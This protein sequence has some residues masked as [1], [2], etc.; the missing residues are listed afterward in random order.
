M[1][2][3]GQLLN[4]NTI[5]QL[6]KTQECALK[7]ETQNCVTNMCTQE[8]EK[9]SKHEYGLLLRKLEEI[10]TAY[11]KSICRIYGVMNVKRALDY[12]LATPNVRNKGGYF[13]YML[14]QFKKDTPQPTAKPQ[15]TENKVLDTNIPK[16][17]KT[18]CKLSQLPQ[19][20]N[21]RD[22]REFLCDYMDGCY[23][24]TDNVIQF[25]QEI[26]RRYNFG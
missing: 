15:T 13:M 25:V 10:G 22:A 4:T 12:T 9:L 26:K 23:D 8:Y 6:C 16:E 18:S 21:W 17:Q 11:P 19:I 3:I 24:N 5:T 20:E 14:R 1:E 2:S 7:K